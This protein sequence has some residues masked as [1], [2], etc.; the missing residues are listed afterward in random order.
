MTPTLSRPTLACGSIRAPNMDTAPFRSGQG[1]VARPRREATLKRKMYDDEGEEEDDD[2]EEEDGGEMEEEEEQIK[3]PNAEATVPCTA[4]T[5]TPKHRCAAP[6]L[7]DLSDMWGGASHPDV[8]VRRSCLIQQADL[9]LSMPLL[10]LFIKF[11]GFQ[12]MS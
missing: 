4:S 10:N 12:N 1:M 3:T 11:H 8:E 9:C 7:Q 6:A 2:E 5:A